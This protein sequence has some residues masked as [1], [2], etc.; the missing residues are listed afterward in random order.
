TYLRYTWI[1]TKLRTTKAA[2]W[3]SSG[4]PGTSSTAR[5]TAAAASP[6]QSM[7]APGASASAAN[8]SSATAAQPTTSQRSSTAQLPAGKVGRG[9][10]GWLPP[11]GADCCLPSASVASSAMPA[12]EP[13]MPLD[14]IGMSTNFWFGAVASFSNASTYFC[15]TK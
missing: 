6:I 8:S 1:D 2:T 5:N 10:G 13:M 7:K 9:G 14:S 4:I 15:A 3:A 12:I 11:R